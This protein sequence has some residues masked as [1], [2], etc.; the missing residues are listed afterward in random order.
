MVEREG[1]F[2]I[3]ATTF[4][5]VNDSIKYSVRRTI[6]KIYNILP[7]TNGYR[8]KGQKGI[9]VLGGTGYLMVYTVHNEDSIRNFR[10]QEESRD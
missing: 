4:S 6:R 2:I 1:D 3:I 10:P 9:F 5:V 7:D 8:Y